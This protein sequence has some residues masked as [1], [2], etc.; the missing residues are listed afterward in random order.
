MLLT[1][2]FPNTKY[3]EIF[4][5]MVFS[6]MRGV[7]TSFDIDFESVHQDLILA[8]IPD[9]FVLI[10]NLNCRPYW[11]SSAAEG[12]VWF[13]S[14]SMRLVTI[15]DRPPY[16]PIWTTILL[17]DAI[18]MIAN[19]P[20]LAH[21]PPSSVLWGGGGGGGWKAAKQGVCTCAGDVI[22]PALLREWSGSRD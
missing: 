15:P 17:G 3:V 5:I 22:H 18:C 16:P 8:R 14:A 10:T 9:K 1:M 12:V 4:N 20:S 19:F 13:T 21:L 11:W 2:F 7:A 6:I